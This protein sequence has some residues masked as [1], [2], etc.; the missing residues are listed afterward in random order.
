MFE[1]KHEV[2]SVDDFLHLRK[3]AGLSRRS[4][5]GAEIALPRSLFAV[6]IYKAELA[7]GMGRVVGDGG[8]NFEVVDIAVDP[9]FQGHGLGRLIMENI[10][11]FLSANAPSDAYVSMLADQPAFYEK[12]GWHKTAPESMGMH[13]KAGTND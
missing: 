5:E 8:C 3:V 10:M 2:P 7:V 12:F 1:A 13:W 11:A 6:T 4:R 9:D